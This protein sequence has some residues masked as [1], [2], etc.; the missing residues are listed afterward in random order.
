M[1]KKLREEIAKFI[2]EISPEEKRR[3]REVQ[4]RI[5]FLNTWLGVLGQAS[6]GRSNMSG[7]FFDNGGNDPSPDLIKGG[8]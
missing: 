7:W 8:R 2:S 3:N 4:E 6:A 5:R 1:F